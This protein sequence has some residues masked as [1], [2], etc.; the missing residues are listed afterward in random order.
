MSL[1]GTDAAKGGAWQLFHKLALNVLFSLISMHSAC[2]VSQEAPITAYRPRFWVLAGMGAIAILLGLI[3]YRTLIELAEDWW[4]EPS[5]SQGLLIPP[6]A[7][8]FAWVDRKKLFALPA[9][10]DARGLIA[11]IG[12]SLMFLLGKL[13]AEFFLQRF[14]FILALVGLIWAGWGLSRLRRLTFPLILLAAMIPLPALIYNAVTA[15]LQLL[16]SG[17]A[18]SIAQFCGVSVYRDG[19]ILQ[20][21]TLSLGVDEACSGL[22]S[23]SALVVSALLVGRFVC[24]GMVSRTLLI[25]LSGPISIAANVLRIAGT[26]ILA[27][28]REELAM[29]FYHLFAGW[30]VFL[31]GFLALAGLAKGFHRFVES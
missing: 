30:L 27:D 4:N 14:S 9:V 7:L 28:Y 18:S 17:V 31:V 5:L 8:Y 2:A 20:L 13:G 24:S 1:G 6:L 22:N 23:F 16:A 15:P 29:G 25:L 26:A 12:A 21:A 10:P 3:Y 11:A 19:N